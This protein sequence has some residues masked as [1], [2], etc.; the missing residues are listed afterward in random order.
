MSLPLRFP[1]SAAKRRESA[2]WPRA[3]LLSLLQTHAGLT[4]VDAGVFALTVL[5]VAGI[6]YG[7]KLHLGKA[8]RQ[9]QAQALGQAAAAA[10]QQQ[11][12][13]PAPTATAAAAAATAAGAAS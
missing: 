9:A 8:E 7:W 12:A 2:P 5:G 11:P 6:A 1:S 3:P 4:R 13:G 10:V